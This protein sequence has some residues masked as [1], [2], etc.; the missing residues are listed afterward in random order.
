VCA[1]TIDIITE[2]KDIS[3]VV[4]GRQGA[5]HRGRRPIRRAARGFEIT[6]KELVKNHRPEDSRPAT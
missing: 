3:C 5:D 6:M 1:R 2:I 4:T